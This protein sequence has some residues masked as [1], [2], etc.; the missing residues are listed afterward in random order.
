MAIALCAVFSVQHNTLHSQTPPAGAG[1]YEKQC[2]TES[3]SRIKEINQDPITEDFDT[4]YESYD[5]LVCRLVEITNIYPD[6]MACDTVT[7]LLRTQ[8]DTIPIPERAI[9]DESAEGFHTITE[10]YDTLY[11]YQ[12]EVRCRRID[13]L[14]TYDTTIQTYKEVIFD[15]ANSADTLR[16]ARPTTHTDTTFTFCPHIINTYSPYAGLAETLIDSIQSIEQQLADLQARWQAAYGD[17]HRATLDYE[18]IALAQIE[19]EYDIC[20]NCFTPLPILPGDTLATRLRDS[21]FR[22]RREAIVDSLTAIAPVTPASLRARLEAFR[23][24]LQEYAANVERTEEY[25]IDS[26]HVIATVH[27]NGLTRTQDFVV[28]T[29][30]MFYR[31][32]PD[33]AVRTEEPVLL[34]AGS[35]FLPDTSGPTPVLSNSTYTSIEWGMPIDA[36]THAPVTPVRGFAPG[37]LYTAAPTALLHP[38][39]AA[40]QRDYTHAGLTNI[41]DS[42]PTAGP[43]YFADTLDG[44]SLLFPIVIRATDANRDRFPGAPEFLCEHHDTIKVLIKSGYEIRGYVSYAGLWFPSQVGD[45]RTPDVATVDGDLDV[46]YH[47]H[48][49]IENAHIYLQ[50]PETGAILD[51]ALSDADGYFRMQKM[52]MEGKY[53]V[54]GRSPQKEYFTGLVGLNGNDVAWIQNYINKR[55]NSVILPENTNPQLSMWWWASNVD[56]SEFPEATLGLS[57]NDITDIQNKITRKLNAPT[58]K[59]RNMETQEWLDDWAYSVDTL[60]L[61]SDTN[62]HVRGVMRGDADRNYDGSETTSGGSPSQMRKGVGRNKI[63]KLDIAQV[64]SLNV[65]NDIRMLDFPIISEDSGWLSGFQIF[66]YYNTDKV[67]PWAA[68]LPNDFDVRFTNFE[69]NVIDD[70]ILTTWVSK[71]PRYF[72]PGDTMLMLNRKLLKKPVKN[73]SGFFKNN[74]LQYVVS[75]TSAHILPEWKVSMPALD[76]YYPEDDGRLVGPTWSIEEGDTIYKV[77]DGETPVRSQGDPIQNH[78]HILAVIPNP[79]ISWGDVTYYVSQSSLVNLKLY[80]MMGECVATFVEG[81]RQFGHYRLSMNIEHLPSGVY[82]LRLETTVHSRTEFDIAKIIIKR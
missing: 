37:T 32:Q 11:Y 78:S 7:T 73:L 12:H 61:V 30:P 40:L 23:A 63:P 27:E 76:V 29:I 3:F 47:R 59:Y 16:L 21:C 44:D 81:E 28:R 42:F 18:A 52:W 2:A 66:L 68:S 70:Q 26:V 25:H 5:S 38:H 71:T 13:T 22:V 45:T 35:P 80:S 43:L 50:D 6:L 4:I 9:L 34:F 64:G 36:A 46:V 60:N 62:F 55:I 33:T 49:P 82:I 19:V 74:P 57:G 77:G 79:I 31:R 24:L 53:V 65:P 39:T 69:Y 56:M 51:T 17:N 58:N 75:D 1:L 67:E 10:L 41:A 54:T 72:Y 14:Y 8:I 15:T 20:P 48:L